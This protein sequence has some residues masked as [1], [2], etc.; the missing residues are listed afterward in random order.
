MCLLHFFSTW[1][2][3][4]SLRPQPKLI[5]QKIQSDVGQHDFSMRYEY[6]RKKE[7]LLYFALPWS[8][9]RRPRYREGLLVCKRHSLS[10]FSTVLLLFGWEMLVLWALACVVS[11]P[12]Q[13]PS[14]PTC[15]SSGLSRQASLVDSPSVA[16]FSNGCFTFGAID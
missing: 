5:T 6:R 11:S 10:K 2:S 9:W 1:S 15:A 16:H 7:C 3:W 13:V 8:S 14:V 12:F 4:P